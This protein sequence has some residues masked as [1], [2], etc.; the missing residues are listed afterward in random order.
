MPNI[1]LPMILIS[2]P[3]AF[4]G[5]SGQSV[6]QIWAQGDPTP[7]EQQAM[8][9]LNAARKDPVGTLDGLLALAGTD[10]VIDA[11]LAG[12][13]GATA[14]QLQQTLQS[15]WTLAQANAA[16]FPNSSAISTAPLAFYPLFQQEAAAAGA[17]ANLPPPDAPPQRPIPEYLYP[18]PVRDTLLSGS[19]NVIAGPDATG[20]MAQFGPYGANYAEVL[21][22]NL[23]APAVTGREYVLSLLA[24]PGS[25]SPPPAFLRQGDP[26]PNLALGH[27]RMA[28]VAISPGSNGGR[29]LTF[30]QG[31]S[32]FFTRSDLPFGNT[33]TVF[34]TGIAYRDKNSNG[35]YDPGEG[36]AGV[37]ISP[38]RGD[39][40]AVTAS[41]GGYAIPVPANSGTYT[42]TATGG[43]FGGAAAAVGVGGENVK[44]DWA[45]PALSPSL[46]P[47]V[48]VPPSDGAT[49]LIGLST[50]GL[51][52][53]GDGTL[54]GGFVISG[55]SSSQKHLLIRGVG[56]SLQTAGFPA[57]E[58]VPATEL[59]LYRGSATIAA[60]TGWTT[61]PDGGA[62]VAQAA[63]QAGDF[64]LL[65]WTG[66][67]GDSALLAA[68][69]PGAYTATV[70]P[71]P[72]TAPEFQTGRVG[73]VEIY[74]L[75]PGDGSRLVNVSTRGRVG[76]GNRQLIVGCTVS[77][78]GHARL[79]VRGA[80]PVLA[81]YGLD[82]GLPD[83]AV[84][85]Y[86]SA[87][88][89]LLTNDD[90]GL[91][92]QT[93][94][95]RILAAAAGAFSFPEGSTDAA[96]LARV[97]PGNYTAIVGARDGTAAT[98]L[99]LVELYEVP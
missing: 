89:P 22:S 85:F 33:A 16:L 82:G 40:C 1:R 50:R 57:G 81:Q 9:W 73:L 61:S 74:D 86:D 5:A 44:A 35:S 66:G 48:P 83:P 78:S 59:R 10:P 31:S 91:S 90:W 93:D 84:S 63:A 19:S 95:V 28:G 20:G 38:D 96:L 6:Q 62:A 92:P 43:P 13:T 67:G 97:A 54:V 7:D 65:N 37:R 70:S 69:P 94:Q 88:S 76:T 15:A 71:A 14:A 4:C 21:Q 98:G 87:G 24:N 46:P 52:E 53:A 8:E 32:E 25:G 36:I 30:Y 3:A 2:L 56:P 26:L 45:L 80:G 47:Q 60:N 49:Q 29:I 17:G 11:F 77:G 72:G 39:W 51:V 18:T 64:P 41:A 68:L 75:S 79:L 99:A 55:P 12:E 58:C 27:T 23:Y 42:L 34:I